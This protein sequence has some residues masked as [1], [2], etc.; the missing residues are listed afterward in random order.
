MNRQREWEKQAE[1]YKT[2]MKIKTFHQYL[3]TINSH[4][5]GLSFYILIWN[6]QRL[7]V[8]IHLPL[9]LELK[10][11]SISRQVLV[12]VYETQVDRKI[13]STPVRLGTCIASKLS[14]RL[15]LLYRKCS[16]CLIRFNESIIGYKSLA[17]E[18]TITFI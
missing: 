13:T 9:R 2:E 16:P 7:Q 14:M 10:S 5:K 15:L 17:V 12:I 8:M 11:I 3:A 6:A 1:K 18:V 4:H